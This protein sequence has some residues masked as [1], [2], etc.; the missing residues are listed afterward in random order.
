MRALL[1]RPAFRFPTLLQI[2]ISILFRL[3]V[4]KN[5]R[6][7]FGPARIDIAFVKLMSGARESIRNRRRNSS[8]STNGFHVEQLVEHPRISATQ[9]NPRMM[10]HTLNEETCENEDF[11]ALKASSSQNS[12]S[13]L[14][15]LSA[16]SSGKR[17][18]SPGG[19][20]KTTSSTSNFFSK[21]ASS[22]NLANL[23]DSL[24]SENHS[25]RKSL[26]EK[27]N[28]AATWVSAKLLKKH[29][30]RRARRLESDKSESSLKEVDKSVSELE[31]LSQHDLA[32]CRLSLADVIKN[33][34]GLRAFKE[35][36]DK[37]HSGEN[38]SFWL[39]SEEYRTEPNRTQKAEQIHEK[40]IKVR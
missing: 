5:R 10:P 40:F 23:S 20:L 12:S 9:F 7:S 21:N 19:L 2:L 4:S 27:V 14:D 6:K 29:R 25:E 22:S 36:L 30:E 38:L 28:F 1:I 16:N 3:G 35:F 18:T 37:E 8:V 33:E 24:D 15:L 17:K 26:P 39:A 34:Q 32:Q 11:F 31:R 13:Q